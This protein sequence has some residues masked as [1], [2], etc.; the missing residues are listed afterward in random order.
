[1]EDWSLPVTVKDVKALQA[2]LVDPALCGYPENNIR[3]LTDSNAT[4]QGILDGLQWLQ[5]RAASDPQA[6]VSSRL[7]YLGQPLPPQHLL[8]Y[9][10]KFQP[11]GCSSFDSCHAEGMATSKEGR[12]SLKLPTGG[13]ILVLLF[14]VR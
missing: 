9:C 6:T 5:Q 11:N 12:L 8:K 3:T 14:Q 7:T 1:L 13:R 10:N 2:I 4:R